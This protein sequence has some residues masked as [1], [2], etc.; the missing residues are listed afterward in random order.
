MKDQTDLNRSI[1][2]PIPVVVALDDMREVE[3]LVMARHLAGM[4][5]GFKIND[6][7][8]RSGAEIVKR[9]R[10]YGKVFCDAKLHDIPNTVANQVRVLEEAGA[11]LITVHGSGGEAMLQAA[12]QAIRGHARVLVVTVLTSLGEED[13]QAIYGRG[14][15]DQV[16]RMASSALAAGVGGVVSSGAEL[17]L[18]NE[19]DP[20]RKLMRVTPGIRPAWHSV[21]DDQR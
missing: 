2:S 1:G 13:C 6:I 5:W 16:R 15:S 9:L 20:Q 3:A 8:L 21:G 17:S 19:V 14:V 4:V 12:A 18:L 11:D 10:G 7:L